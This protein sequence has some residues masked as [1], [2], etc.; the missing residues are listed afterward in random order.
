MPLSEFLRL[1][2]EKLEAGKQKSSSADPSSRTENDTVE[3]VYE[4]G[5]ITMQ[6]S[7]SRVKRSPT[8][9]NLPSR[10]RNG[11][12]GEVESIP[13][14][15]SPAVPSGDFDLSQKDEIVPWLSYPINDGLQDLPEI[16]GV[17]VNEMS[18]RNSF[19]D[20]GSS[21]D[22][23]ESFLDNGK[24]SSKACPLFS[25]PPQQSQTS[26]PSLGSGVSD[27][28][29]NNTRNGM[30]PENI[31]V[32]CNNSSLLNFSGFSRPANAI[33]SR[34][35]AK[36]PNDSF[37]S[38][39]TENLCQETPT[40]NEKVLIQCNSDGAVEPIGASSSVGSGNSADRVSYE[41]THKLKRK[42]GDLE[43]S[44]CHN[45]RRRDRINEKMRALQE[46]IPNC[47]KADKASMLDDAIEYL[48]NLQHQVQIMSMGGGFYMPPMMFPPGIQHMY[49]A[50]VPH[51][52][53]MGV[54]MGM[55]MNGKS[56]Q[57]PIFPVPPMQRL[58]FPSST[59]AP[60]SFPRIPGSNIPEYGHPSRGIH[61]SVPRAPLVPLAVRPHVTSA[62]GSR[63]VRGSSHSEVP[64]TCSKLSSENL[65]T[66]KN[67]EFM[68]DAENSSSIKHGSKQLPE[69]VLDQSATVQEKNQATD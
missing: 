2:I 11:T 30:E 65:S 3:L 10:T 62:M 51:F 58:H 49:P 63:A 66:K 18:A 69:V 6:G 52:S 38:E 35:V 13:N 9:H 56:P 36:R 60:T 5:Q 8:L 50:H 42:S 27:I 25:W 4:D 29:S 33:K 24:F 22:R 39:R 15:S 1:A 26:E 59:T 31:A 57:C 68:H 67:S 14:D 40:K 46:L 17:T 45:E 23:A 32:P 16:S 48:K 34:L 20:N 44:E 64:S 37:L 53:Q 55:G 61:S 7:E 54:G 12:F 47:N 19:V 21:R 43:E 28:V 41:Q